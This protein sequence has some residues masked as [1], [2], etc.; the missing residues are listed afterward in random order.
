MKNNDL[1]SKKIES[2][3]EYLYEQEN[4]LKPYLTKLSDIIK[5][6]IDEEELSAKEAFD[7]YLAIQSQYT[8]SFLLMAKLKEVIDFRE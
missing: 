7:M 1:L 2:A 6:K 3:L 5:K 4:L 8:N